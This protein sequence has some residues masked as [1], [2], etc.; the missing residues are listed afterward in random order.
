VT[1]GTAGRPLRQ[2]PTLAA[3]LEHIAAAV[4]LDGAI[5][6]GSFAG[7]TPDAAS[8][9]DL[10]VCVGE[11]YFA[12]AW[13][14]R[15]AMRVTG[16]MVWWDQDLVSDRMGTHKWITDD[17]VLVECLLAAPASGV[18]LATPHRVVVGDPALAERFVARPPIE[19][20]ELGA[21]VHPVERAYDQL[22]QVIRSHGRERAAPYPG[23]HGRAP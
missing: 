16:A 3:L 23:S 2:L 20:A 14:D 18:R 6:L 10:I 17:L 22:K 9:L 15:A 19:R 5:L 4:S 8:D 12:T 21:D 1:G 13:Q 7:G 11:G